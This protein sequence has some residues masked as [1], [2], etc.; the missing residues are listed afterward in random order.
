LLESD[1]GEEGRLGVLIGLAVGDLLAI[2]MVRDCVGVTLPSE[3]KVAEVTLISL[4][5]SGIVPTTEG[6][7]APWYD[8]TMGVDTGGVDARVL[9]GRDDG[10]DGRDENW[11]G[12]GA[13]GT[14][15]DCVELGHLME[16]E[17]L[18]T[19]SGVDTGTP[20]FK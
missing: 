6:V 4:A 8:L 10:R 13:R 16:L 12:D 7:G 9:E 1:R 15:A 19:R 17:Y 11:A 2:D 20:P 3:D 14:V 5:A 18:S